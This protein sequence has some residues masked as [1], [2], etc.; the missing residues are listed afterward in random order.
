MHA[1][2][3]HNRPPPASDLVIEGLPRIK[4]DEATLGASTAKDLN[5]S[6]T[7]DADPFFAEAS[8]YKDCSVCLTEFELGQEVIRIPC[9]CVTLRH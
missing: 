8:Q 5:V 7:G 4:L 1:A 2:G 9:K 6:G 3:E